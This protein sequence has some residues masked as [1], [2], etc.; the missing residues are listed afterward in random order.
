MRRT[1]ITTD[2]IVSMTVP[3]GHRS[4]TLRGYANSDS[5]KAAQGRDTNLRLSAENLDWLLA[6][7]VAEPEYAARMSTMLSV[8]RAL[9][10]MVDTTSPVHSVRIRN[11]LAEEVHAAIRN[12]HYTPDLDTYPEVRR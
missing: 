9:T 8:R 5:L 11:H 12:E 10:G 4:I 6:T 2:G 7:L 1:E 3:Y